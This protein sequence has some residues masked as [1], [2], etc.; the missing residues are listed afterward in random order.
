[1]SR[2]LAFWLGAAALL[3]SVVGMIAFGWLEARTGASNWHTDPVGEVM[4]VVALLM[5]PVMGM[6]IVSRAPGNVVGWTFCAVGLVTGLG[7]AA[8][9][10]AAST[11]RGSA[12]PGPLGVATAWVTNWW[13]FPLLGLVMIVAPFLFPTGRLPSRRWRFLFW[14]GVLSVGVITFIGMTSPRLSATAEGSDRV[15]YDIGN[16]LGIDGLG[17]PEEDPIGAVAFGG[18]AVGMIAAAASVVARFIWSRGVER[19]QIKWFAAAGALIPVTVLLEEFLGDVFQDSN[20]PFALTIGALPAAAG[21]AIL[22]YRLYDI[23]VVINRALVYASLTAILGGLYVGIVFGMHALLAPVTSESDLAIAASTL[24]VAG[25]FGPV[26]SRV[27]RFIDH[28]FYRRKFNAQRT[29]EEFNSHLRDQV[30]LSAVTA[31]LVD[32]VRDTMQ[33]SHVSL[34]LREEAAS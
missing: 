1:M 6:L 12:D 14:L 21:I 4:L 10:Y 34:W 22:R 16:P 24:A 30:E 28:R 26:R 17:D 8:Q 2:R 20:A 13:W 19:Q 15:L 31:Q 3:I 18:V 11:I 25:L 5:F 7:G 32:V 9:S 33:P 23:D 29:V 27:Q